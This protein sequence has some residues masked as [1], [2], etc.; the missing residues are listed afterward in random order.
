M[1]ETFS[2]NAEVREDTGKG[3][4]R[5]ARIQRIVQDAEGGQV[6]VHPSRSEDEGRRSAGYLPWRSA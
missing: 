5:R 4:A 2:L 6:H 3:A 1:A